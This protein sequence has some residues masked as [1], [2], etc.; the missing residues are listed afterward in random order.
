VDV[1]IV[2][3]ACDAGKY[4]Q[5][6]ERHDQAETVL[7]D[8]EHNLIQSTAGIPKVVPASPL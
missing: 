6:D 3:G 8:V 7:H 5:D 4:D 1:M 2:G